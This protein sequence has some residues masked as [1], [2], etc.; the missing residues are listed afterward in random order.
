MENEM[1]PKQ[2]LEGKAGGIIRKDRSRKGWLDNVPDD[3]TEVGAKMWRKEAMG[4]NVKA[5][6]VLQEL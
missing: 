2:V 4:E 5:I 3:M 1:L 6:K